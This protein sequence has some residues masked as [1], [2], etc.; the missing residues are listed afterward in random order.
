MLER[1]ALPNEAI[2]ECL[3]GR[4]G[5]AVADVQFLPL[6]ADINAAV[7]RLTGDD[8]GDY[9]LKLRRGDFDKT[10]V[11]VARFLADRGIAAVIP[12]MTTI[13]GRLWTALGGFTA[14]L[15]PF[16]AGENGYDAEMTEGDWLQ[17]G[18]A[19]R[20]IHGL[21]I[22]GDLATQI[23]WEDYNPT[24]RERVRRYMDRF[25]IEYFTDPVTVQL[26][27]FLHGK[28]EIVLDLVS[29]AESYAHQLQA[30]PR[31][32][33]LCH[34]DAHAGNVLLGPGDAFHIVDWD[35]PILAPKERDL[36]YPGGGQGFRGHSAAEE[37]ALFYRGYGAVTVDPVGIA[38]YRFERIVQDIMAFCDQLVLSDEGDANRHQALRWVMANFAPGGVIEVAYEG[39][40]IIP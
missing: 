20:R 7:F 1:P 28:R 39:A 27:Q 5:I 4:F 25:A 32:F 16:V 10:P 35:E 11:T 23:R 36:M 33:V 34:S 8:G 3:R 21:A 22:P 30:E 17:F 29:R 19:L 9:F 38:Y 13:D 31:P 14:V 40:Q 15:Y 6:G 26:A 37:E 2:V 18:A 12:P 24:G